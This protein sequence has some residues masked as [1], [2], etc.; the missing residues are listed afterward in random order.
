[1]EVYEFINS[2]D[3]HTPKAMQNF[4]NWATSSQVEKSGEGRRQLGYL[5][6]YKGSKP[7]SQNVDYLRGYEQ[8]L[9]MRNV[10]LQSI[11]FG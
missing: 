3:W 1:M 9:A 10:N 8:G 6:G 7:S 2:T 4:F 5:D 11:H